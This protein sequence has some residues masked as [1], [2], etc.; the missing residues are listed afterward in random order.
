MKCL[1]CEYESDNKEDFNDSSPGRS[2]CKMRGT[3]ECVRDWYTIHFMQDSKHSA[4]SVEDKIKEIKAK[5]KLDRKRKLN[6]TIL[7]G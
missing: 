4:E 3:W 2:L 6:E 5:A 7:S 1:I